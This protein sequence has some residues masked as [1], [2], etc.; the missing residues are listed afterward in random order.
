[1]TATKLTVEAKI[2]APVHEVWRAWNTPDD[3]K[4]WNAASAD[5]HTTKATVDLRVG[6]GFSSRM[7]AKDGS[8]GFDFAGTFTKVIEHE[9]IESSFGD[10]VLLVEF[11]SGPDGVTVRETFDAETT[12][13]I[14]QQRQGWQ[15]ILNNFARHVEGRRRA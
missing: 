9:L 4:Q 10:R 8:M 1:V 15:A 13:P 2:A 7:E 6:G 12:Y 3:I 14:E 11:L 5:W